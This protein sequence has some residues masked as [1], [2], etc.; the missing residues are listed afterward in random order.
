MLISMTGSLSLQS[1]VDL[2]ETQ[3]WELA[4]CC[5]CCVCFWGNNKVKYKCHSFLSLLKM[6]WT[7]FNHFWT[8]DHQIVLVES[9]KSTF[10]LKSSTS[11]GSCPLSLS[12]KWKRNRTWQMN[13]DMHHRVPYLVFFYVFLQWPCNF[14]P[15]PKLQPDVTEIFE[16]LHWK[17]EKM[18]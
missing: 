6:W 18:A 13:I 7:Y 9:V 10:L 14:C 15:W 16:I 11:F 8:S 3:L 2:C 17:Q 12:V 1:Q 5:C 4:F